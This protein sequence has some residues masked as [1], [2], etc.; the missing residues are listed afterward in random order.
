MQEKFIPRTLFLRGKYIDELELGTEEF[1]I[2]SA[3][4]GGPLTRYELHVITKIP[5]S[6][7]YFM[8]IRLEANKYITS[9]LI[10]TKRGRPQYIFKRID[11]VPP[12]SFIQPK[13]KLTK[14]IYYD[15]I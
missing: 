1:D 11:Y 12:D 9:T 7:L 15:Y 13:K 3:L 5:L 14:F 8:L 4:E 6:T 10:R 2:L